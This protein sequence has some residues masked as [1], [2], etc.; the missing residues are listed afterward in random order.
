MLRRK[1]RL[2]EAEGDAQ[3]GD[4]VLRQGQSVEIALAGDSRPQSG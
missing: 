2:A 1:D 3:V 4:E